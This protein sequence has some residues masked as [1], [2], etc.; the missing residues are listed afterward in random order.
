MLFFRE[1]FKIFGYFLAE[2]NDIKILLCRSS[3]SLGN[4]EVFIAVI[5]VEHLLSFAFGRSGAL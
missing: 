4:K 5:H 2:G 1:F 3:I